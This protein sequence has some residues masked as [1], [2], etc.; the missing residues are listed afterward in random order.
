MRKEPLRRFFFVCAENYIFAPSDEGA[1][2]E[3]DWGRDRRCTGLLAVIVSP[4]GASRHLPRQREALICV[5]VDIYR[6]VFY[7]ENI[8][9]TGRNTDGRL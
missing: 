7:T 1:V 8:N 3:G 5:L 2:T 4:T 9:I 6:T